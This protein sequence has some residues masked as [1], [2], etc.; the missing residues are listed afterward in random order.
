MDSSLVKTSV[1]LLTLVSCQAPPEISAPARYGSGVAGRIASASDHLQPE[2]Y[3]ANRRLREAHAERRPLRRVAKGTRLGLAAN[4]DASGVVPILNVDLLRV[5][6]PEQDPH[7]AALRLADAR[8]AHHLEIKRALRAYRAA[9][10]AAQAARITAETARRRQADALKLRQ[11]G[12]ATGLDVADAQRQ[13][14]VATLE[15][16]QAANQKANALDDLQAVTGLTPSAL[17]PYLA[18]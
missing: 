16:Q 15:E 2:I 8:R 18:E 13:T 17:L 9:D 10:Q 3:S 11:G 12:E 1:L 7:E 6:D 5:I 4:S 14:A